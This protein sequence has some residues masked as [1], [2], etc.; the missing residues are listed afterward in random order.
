VLV[1]EPYGSAPRALWLA[2]FGAGVVLRVALFSGY[3]LGDDPN[4]FIAFNMIA[5]ANT[6]YPSDPYQMRFGMWVPVVIAMKLFGQTE[7]GFVGGMLAC[8]IF[9]LVLIYLLA[10]QEWT[11]PYALLAMA[12]LAVYPLDV[13]CSTLFA[14]DMMLG[15]WSF[16]SLFLYRKALAEPM[17]P[18]VRFGCIVGS[19]LFALFGFVTK[20]WLVMMIPVFA[21]EALRR[22]DAWR[23][24]VLTAVAAGVSLSA[25]V[26]WQWMRFGDPLYH[27]DVARP[28]ALFLPYSREL[29]LEYPRMLFFPNEYGSRFAGYYPHLVI[30]L[31]LLFVWRAPGAL[32]WLVYFV[33]LLAGL[34]ALPAGRRDGEWV[35][36]VPHIFR[37]LASVSIPL[38]LALTALLRELSRRRIVMGFVVIA[39]VL[40]TSVVQSVALTEPSRDAFGEERRANAVLRRFPDEPVM[41]DHHLFGRLFNFAW[42]T[43]HAERLHPLLGVTREERMREYAAFAEGMVVTGGARMPWYGCVTC[44]SNL[45]GFVPPPTWTLVAKFDDRP[46][47][48]YRLE[49]LQVWHVSR[50]APRAKELRAD[51]PDPAEQRALLHRLAGGEDLMV[52]VALGHDLLVTTPDDADVAYVTGTA[53]FQLRRTTCATELLTRALRYGLGADA[54]RDALA[55][56]VAVREQELDFAG[57]RRWAAELKRRVPTYQS[58]ELD[59]LESGMSEAVAQYQEG[60]L[61]DAL[62]GF[63]AIALRPDTPDERRRRAF[64][65]AALTVFGMR[66]VGAGVGW[67]AAYRARYGAD[68]AWVELRY[69]EGDAQRI[70]N[71]RAAHE[72][73]TDLVTN[74]PNTYWAKLAATQLQAK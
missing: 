66:R 6:Y 3:G 12:L 60:W 13:L 8:S 21:I 42:N 11:W 59:E 32:R 35:T 67:A 50:A 70:T 10:R 69:R 16:T 17:R 38:C 28:L 19:G 41:S 68:A 63:S 58:A 37:Y 39:V 29:L 56:L 71:R 72:V 23:V 5:R 46:L 36:L 55:K 33:I 61:P 20:P 15:T 34:A 45:D 51:H 24:S 1:R 4:Y 25:Y 47:G 54:T 53:C 62:R 27:I 49:P 44:N 18:A 2:V 57:A 48:A 7:L 9:N 14:N 65:Y 26:F 52:A 31:A 73:F 43:R 30:A 64:Y 22:R 74:H 40:V